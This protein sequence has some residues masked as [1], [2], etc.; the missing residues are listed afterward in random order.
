MM[1]LV[2]KL[3]SFLLLTVSAP[4]ETGGGDEE[5]GETFKIADVRHVPA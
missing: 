3:F 1:Q 5:V 4:P 2:M